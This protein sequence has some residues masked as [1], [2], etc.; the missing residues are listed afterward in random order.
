[1]PREHVECSTQ[2]SVAKRRR[3]PNI[4]EAGGLSVFGARVLFRFQP[5]EPDFDEEELRRLEQS[6]QKRY[7][8]AEVLAHLSVRA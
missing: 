5:W 6:N 8:T 4:N 3:T 2:S 7:T 1:M